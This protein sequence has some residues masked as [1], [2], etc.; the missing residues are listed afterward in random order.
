VEV[1]QPGNNTGAIYES[2]GRGWLNEIPDNRENI[3]NPGEWN[4]L[5]ICVKGNHVQ[6][7]LNG[8]SMTDLFDDA[9]GKGQGVIALQVHSGGGVAVEWRN[10]S[11]KIKN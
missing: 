3:L 10:I 9:V 2:G 1:A 11:L 7:W 4:D 6:S 5:V 8:E